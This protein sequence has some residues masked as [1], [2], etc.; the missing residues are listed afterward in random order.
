MPRANEKV[1]AVAFANTGVVV[2]SRNG[3]AGRGGGGQAS[4]ARRPFF[5]HLCPFLTTLGGGPAA[6]PTLSR[7]SLLKMTKALITRRPLPP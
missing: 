3:T 2:P 4:E 1:H 6:R 7:H 5:H